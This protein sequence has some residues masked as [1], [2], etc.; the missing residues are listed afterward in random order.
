MTH[1]ILEMLTAVA[2]WQQWREQKI[3]GLP[4]HQVRTVSILIS[5][6]LS[7]IAIIAAKGRKCKRSKQDISAAVSTDDNQSSILPDQQASSSSTKGAVIIPAAN[8]CSST[9]GKMLTGAGKYAREEEIA[10]ADKPT[11]KKARM[12]KWADLPTRTS[13][14]YVWHLLS[15]LH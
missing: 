7:D 14:Q 4:L 12:A 8:K 13:R 15:S 10:D 3:I 6:G 9:Q 5:T 11:K 2:V 1:L